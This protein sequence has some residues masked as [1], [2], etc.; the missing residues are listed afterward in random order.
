[1]N[2]LQRTIR[3]LNETDL[4][5]YQVADATG[6]KTRWV[7]M[8]RNNELPNAACVKVEKVYLFLLERQHSLN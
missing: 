3:L 8:L 5:P 4:T 7:Y 6:L 2:Y 1:M